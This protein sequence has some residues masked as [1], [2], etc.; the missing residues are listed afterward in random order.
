MQTPS[1]QIKEFHQHYMLVLE[2][3]SILRQTLGLTL[4]IL[5][6]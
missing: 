3:E 1:P 4:A 2:K 6:L 5:I